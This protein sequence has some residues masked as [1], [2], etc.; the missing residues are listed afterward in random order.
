MM[1]HQDPFGLARRSRRVDHI[2]QIVRPNGVLRIRAV[3]AVGLF[4]VQ[5]DHI[6]GERYAL[7]QTTPR[8]QQLRLRILQHITDAF[9]RILRINRHVRA[10]GFQDPQNPDDHLERT[11]DHK[12]D[13]LVPAHAPGSQRPSQPVRS[14]VQLPVCQPFVLEYYGDMIRGAFRLL[15]DQPMNRLPPLIIRLRIVERLKQLPFL[16]LGQHVRM[17]NGELRLEQHDGKQLIQMGNGTSHKFFV[18]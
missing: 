17:T 13:Q 8:Q 12:P 2:G 15:L 16:R 7:Q 10:S 14:L 4:V 1:L 18:I 5:R 6:S 11:A 9:F 3:F